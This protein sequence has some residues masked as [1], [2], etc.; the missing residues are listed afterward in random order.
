MH[1]RPL[2]I[3]TQ[4]I[5]FGLRHEEEWGWRLALG[6]ACAPALLLTLGGLL[7]PGERSAPCWREAMD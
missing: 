6:L 7:L 2:P 5:N 3:P 1:G 4:L